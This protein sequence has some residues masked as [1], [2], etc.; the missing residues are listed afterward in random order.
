[1]AI[2]LTTTAF[3]KLICHFSNILKYK[4]YHFQMNE[5]YTKGKIPLS[6]SFHSIMFKQYYKCYHSLKHKLN[7]DYII[8]NEALVSC[9][10]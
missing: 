8:A 4:E 5:T 1:M 2:K 10:L 9:Y 7:Y 3:F 6:K